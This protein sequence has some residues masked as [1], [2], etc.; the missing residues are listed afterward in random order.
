MIPVFVFLLQAVSVRSLSVHLASSFEENSELQFRSE[1]AD[2]VEKHGRHYKEGTQEYE[3]RLD[4]GELFGGS[5][6]SC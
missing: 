1:F 3:D 2:F 6:A 5:Q 4:F